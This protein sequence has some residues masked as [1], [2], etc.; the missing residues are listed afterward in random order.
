MFRKQGVIPYAIVF[1]SAWC[2][3]ILFVKSRKLAFQKK[4]LS[5]DVIPEDVDFVLTAANVD[6]VLDRVYEIA[7]EPRNFVLFNRIYVALANL[8]NLG[9]VGDVGEILRSQ[10]E[11]DESAVETSY[12]L[13]AGF[14]WAIP[15][16]GFIG[17]VMGLSDAIGGFGSVLEQTDEIEEIK[18]ALT[19]VT[20]GLS[21][22]FVTTLQALV[23]ALCIQLLLT[24]VK[25]SEQQFLDDCSQYCTDQV[26]NHLRIMPF[27]RLN[28]E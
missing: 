13:L 1:F 9:R 10:A 4:S 19:K 7:D 28:Q 11:N 20:G 22:A 25:K 14:I 3:A 2:L 12:S 24:F 18:G 16:L 8:R 6:I 17:T 26:V 23:A 21:T 5:F 15:V 27:E